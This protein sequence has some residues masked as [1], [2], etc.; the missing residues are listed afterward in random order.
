MIKRTQP[1]HS[2]PVHA[3]DD[4]STNICWMHDTS[5]QDKYSPSRWLITNTLRNLISK[6]WPAFNRC[7]KL[8]DILIIERPEKEEH[9]Q[10][11]SH[12]HTHTLKINIWFDTAF[13][14]T[15]SVEQS[16]MWPPTPITEWWQWPCGFSW[17]T[18]TPPTPGWCRMT[19]KRVTAAW[20]KL[21][22][23]IIMYQ[24]RSFPWR[25]GD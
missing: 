10:I 4:R 19:C 12:T 6:N 14:F 3:N 18:E 8:L 16:R 23:Q 9:P 17:V 7:L 21:W 1:S 5:T 13:T 25:I 22:W 11:S 2:G 15:R 20:G 24:K